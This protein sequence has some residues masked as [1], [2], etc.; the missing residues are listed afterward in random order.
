M[1]E[2]KKERRKERTKQKEKEGVPASRDGDSN[3]NLAS[4]TFALDLSAA[5]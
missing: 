1:K 4:I 5:E 2:E 3:I